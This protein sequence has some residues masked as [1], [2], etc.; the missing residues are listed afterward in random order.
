VTTRALKAPSIDRDLLGAFTEHLTTIGFTDEGVRTAAG[1]QSASDPWSFASGDLRADE[2]PLSVV[3]KL[4]CYGVAVERRLADAAFNSAVDVASLEE[5]ELVERHEDVVRP[6]CLIRPYHGLLVA[7]DLPGSQTE[8]V[9]GAVPASET[10]ARLTIRKPAARALDLGTG[11]GLQALLLA[12]HVSRVAA[13]DINPHATALASFNAALNNLPGI[14]VRE[15]SWF[16]PVAGERFDIIACNPP[17]VISPDTSFTYR[18]GGLTRDHVSR[19]VIRES[20]AHLANEGFATVLCNWIHGGD[21]AA[22]IRP[23]L[24]Q[25]GCD[26]LILHYASVDPVSYAQRWN[27]ELRA[28]DRQA[29]DATVRRWVDYFRRE[30]VEQ[31]AFGGVIL[32]RRDTSTHWVRALH[33]S[34]GPTGSCSDQILRLFD[35]ADFLESPR[36]HDL[37]AHGYALVDGHAIDQTLRY[38]DGQY[39]VAPAIFRSVPGLGLEAPIDARALEV[40]LECTADR[41]LGDL[42]E[43][44]ANDR[45]E[46]AS[47]VKTL[48]GDTVR[49]L[50]ENGFMVPVVN[51]S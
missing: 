34:E 38:R 19:M 50:V 22:A 43:Q 12:Q 20:A 44:T 24:E 31:I 25:T 47:D 21:W 9:L 11:C 4:F 42:V 7:S 39:A 23:W 17:Y 10:L 14:D 15:G 37:F 16:G 13:I 6:L 35:A 3:I 48:V 46:P 2:S 18:D 5:L 40:V 1:S 30:G 33:M 29:Y 41:R 49:Q 45:G 26:A 32:R 8:I 28:R 27:M 51:E 36:G